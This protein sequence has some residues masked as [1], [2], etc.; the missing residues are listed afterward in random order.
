MSYT[1]WFCP[2]CGEKTFLWEPYDKQPK[3]KTGIKYWLHGVCT[4]CGYEPKT[5][6]SFRIVGEREE[7]MDKMRHY[8]PDT[9]ERG[10]VGMKLYRQKRAISNMNAVL[11]DD[12]LDPKIRRDRND[13][14]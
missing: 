2:S 7:W 3:I 6:K 13:I 9:E 8:K 10:K 5:D 12:R 4:K 11:Y 14:F 1:D